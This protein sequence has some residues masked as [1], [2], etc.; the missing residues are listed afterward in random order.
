M[1][2]IPT[3][4]EVEGLVLEQKLEIGRDALRHALICAQG[5]PAVFYMSSFPVGTRDLLL[6]ELASAGWKIKFEIDYIHEN[7][8]YIISPKR[9]PKR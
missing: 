6:A 4:S 8:Y 2:Q 5:K 9:Q 7:D 3:P 1:N